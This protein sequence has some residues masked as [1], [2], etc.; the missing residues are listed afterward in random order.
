M[1]VLS[2]KIFAAIVFWLALFPARGL[3]AQGSV[4][5]A[6]PDFD[7]FYT[8]GDGS[9]GAWIPFK[10]SNPGPSIWKTRPGEEGWR[11]APALWVYGDAKPFDG[12]V[13]QV[14]AVTPGRGYHFEVAWAVVRFNGGSGPQDHSKLIRLVG[15]DPFGGTNPLASTVQWSG[16]YGGSGKFAPELSIDQYA[17]SDHITIFLRARNEYTDARAEVFF[18]HAPLTENPG[19][20]PIT[21]SSP[22]PTRVSVTLPVPTTPRAASTRIAQASTRTPT[23]IATATVIPTATD[24]P[25]P[26]ATRTPRPTRFVAESDNSSGGSPIAGIMLL[27]GVAVVGGI[28]ISFFGVVMYRLLGRAD[29]G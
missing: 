11:S 22:T 13:Y 21:V 5:N 4:L 15:I 7:N 2:I 14:V 10:I 6:D 8:S 9:P 3:E 23:A 20:P 1:R 17:R 28:G 18:D 12:G 16:E 25:Q 19:M 26:T 24:S 27:I 29:I